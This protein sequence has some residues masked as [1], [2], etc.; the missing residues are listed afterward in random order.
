MDKDNNDATF[1]IEGNPGQNNT[2][3]SIGTAYNVNPNATKV[4]NTFVIGSREED[5]AAM[6]EAT[7]GKKLGAMT[8]REMLKNN[9]IDTG[10]IQDGI[11]NYVSCIRTKV[12]KTLDKKFMALWAI[13][14]EHEAFSVDLYDPGKQ[15]CTFNRNLVANIIH[16][17]DGKGFYEDPYSAAGMTRA[18][19]GGEDQHP[20]RSALGKDPEDKYCKVVDEILS[21]L[22]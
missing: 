3:I 15:K 18:L 4:E 17:L 13:I 7:G 1:K 10:N 14:V 2:F 6:A 9:L 20:V 11:I 19:E 5:D 21:G 8:L 16:Y 22:E 12:K